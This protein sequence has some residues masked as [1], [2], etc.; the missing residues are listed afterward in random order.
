MIW[1]LRVPSGAQAYFV[2]RA[3][4]QFP[5]EEVILA[6]G[7]ELKPNGNY[8]RQMVDFELSEEY[9][10]TTAKSVVEVEV[11]IYEVTFNSNRS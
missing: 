3:T 9:L 6:A 5:E 2:G 1:E 7:F 11:Q 8:K 10:C 4:E